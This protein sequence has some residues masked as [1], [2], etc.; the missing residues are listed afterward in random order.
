MAT[1]SQ[2]NIQLAHIY[3]NTM[4]DAACDEGHMERVLEVRNEL[5]KLMYLIG[6]DIT[7]SNAL[8]NAQFT[9]EQRYDLAKAIF[10]DA[11]LAVS[12]VLAVMAERGDIKLLK[13]VFQDYNDMLAKFQNIMVVD[14]FTVVPLDDK[15]RAQ[16]IKKAETELGCKIVLNELIDKSILGGIIMRA[17]NHRIDASLRTQLA[18]ARAVLKENYSDGGES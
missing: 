8:N 13:R 16:I 12:E 7:L 9:G 6:K 14:V 15:L 5:E 3:A 2:M 4:Y 11:D 10:A 17:G 18:N 1:K